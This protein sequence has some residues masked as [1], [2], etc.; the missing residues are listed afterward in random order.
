MTIERILD[1]SSASCGMI[2][3]EDEVVAAKLERSVFCNKTKVIDHHGSEISRADC[4][5]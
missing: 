2:E 1:S 5:Q 3:F 4:S